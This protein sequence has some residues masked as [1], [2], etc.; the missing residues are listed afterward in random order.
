MVLNK[1]VSDIDLYT[2]LDI[3]QIQET[4]FGVFSHR[5]CQI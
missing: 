1:Q 4:S 5:S 3:L 2:K